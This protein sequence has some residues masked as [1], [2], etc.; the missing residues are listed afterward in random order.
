MK[1]ERSSMHYSVK[2]KMPQETMAWATVHC[3]PDG[4]EAVTSC[5]LFRLR[6]AEKPAGINVARQATGRYPAQ[7]V[8]TSS[9]GAV[10]EARRS[11]PARER[12]TIGRRWTVLR[13]LILLNNFTR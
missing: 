3:K 4:W 5:S 12:I 8:D 11:R 13:G 1:R 6:F 9:I 10:V 7:I 2:W